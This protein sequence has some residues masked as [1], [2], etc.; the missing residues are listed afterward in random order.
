[1]QFPRVLPKSDPSDQQ[2]FSSVN[3]RA[4]IDVVFEVIT[5]LELF[6]ELDPPVLSCE[7]TSEHRRG[8]GVTSHWVAI[9]DDLSKQIE[10]DEE[11]IQHE[12][13]H[14]YAFRV[15]Q[16]DEV[17]EGVH[18]L[19]ANSDGTVTDEFWE[20]FH[21]AVDASKRQQSIDGLLENAKREAEARAQRS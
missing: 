5:D 15:T 8:V 18:T 6:A 20:T 19:T 2:L 14:Q 12:S 10:W 7:I 17:Y 21:F 13:P 1:M 16:G 4:P 9:S 3:I 11:I